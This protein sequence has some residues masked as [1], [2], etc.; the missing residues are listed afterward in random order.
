MNKDKKV[1]YIKNRKQNQIDTLQDDIKEI[2]TKLEDDYPKVFKAETR[3]NK[4]KSLTDQAE[5]DVSEN[6]NDLKEYGE[7]L[8]YFS[9]ESFNN[10]KL[11]KIV[12]SGHN[13]QKNGRKEDW[14][15]LFDSRYNYNVQVT[16][17][18]KKNLKH[19]LLLNLQFLLVRKR[20]LKE[21]KQI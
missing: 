6:V 8:K 11:Y 9:K 7:Y 3:K 18:A 4:I 13:I 10:S 21:L 14:V 20:F 16:E 1:E 12:E 19:S 2:K 5:E 15:P 17:K